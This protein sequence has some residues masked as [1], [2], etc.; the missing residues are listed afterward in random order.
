MKL[1]QFTNK[2][3]QIEGIRG[4]AAF[5]VFI[6]HACPFPNKGISRLLYFG[7]EAVI[8][9]FLLSGFVISYATDG[10]QITTQNYLHLRIRRIYPIFLISLLLAYVAQ[11]FIAGHLIT[12]DFKSL[13]G[14]LVMLQDVSAIKRGVWFDTFCNNQ[15]LWSLSY[16]FWFYLLFI[17]L[18]LNNAGHGRNSSLKALLVSILGFASY[19]YQPNQLGLIAGYYFIWWSGVEL[20]REYRASNGLSFA[21]Q[22]RMLA[23]ITAMTAFW[24]A[25]VLVKLMEH[26]PMNLWHDPVL[27]FRNY[28]SALIICI[29]AIFVTS[30]RIN[31]KWILVPFA[32]LA[33]VSYAIYLIHD[34]I[35]QMTSHSLSTSPKWLIALAAFPM[36]LLLAWLLEAKVQPWANT[37]LFRGTLYKKQGQT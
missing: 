27:Q 4:F 12:L 33:P 7:P 19:Q 5:Y 24:S 6:F 31:L 3:V 36:V 22:K 21:G 2:I 23:G 26:A 18:G 35:L 20:A 34:P 10:K 15:P 37:M 28:F 9:F 17:P 14:N 13:L 1:K 30:N 16:E 29:T 32:R 25:P 8:V 11:A